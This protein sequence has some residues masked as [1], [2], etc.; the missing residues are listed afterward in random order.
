MRKLLAVVVVPILIGLVVVAIGWSFVSGRGVS[1]RD[2]PSEIEKMV[3]RRMRHLA[4]PRGARE[5]ANPVASSPEVIEQGLAHFADHCAI[6]HA[7]DGS[8][9]SEI[10]RNL[11]PKPP[12]M[13]ATDTQSL[14]DGELFYIIENGVRLTGMPAWG[15]GHAGTDGA[16]GHETWH[17][18]HF[19]R[20]LPKLTPEERARM[21]QLNPKTADEWREQEEARKASEGAEAGKPAPEPTK[22]P[23]PHQHQH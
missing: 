10:G 7:N 18:V 2:E 14:T 22:K 3:A 16:E 6:C 5:Q 19:I 4:I 11:Y 23:H 8:G 1:A 13:R 17:L 20:H 21:A 15:A 9:D 12:D